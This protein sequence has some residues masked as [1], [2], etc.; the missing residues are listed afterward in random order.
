[1]RPGDPPEKP[2]SR[3][4]LNGHHVAGRVAL[5]EELP[6]PVIVPPVP[7]AGHE[8]VDPMV[9]GFHSSGP[10]VVRWMAGLAG[11]EN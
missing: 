10:V 11:L 8:S 6:T 2:P 3:S 1:V 4:L 5:F 9:K 7:H